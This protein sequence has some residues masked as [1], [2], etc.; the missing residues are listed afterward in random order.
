MT[1]GQAVENAGVIQGLLTGE[2]IFSI[3]SQLA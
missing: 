2:L 1:A 3:L